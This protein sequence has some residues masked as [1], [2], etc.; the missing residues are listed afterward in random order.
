MGGP[1]IESTHPCPCGCGRGVSHGRLSCPTS[2]A[3]L[4]R[5]APD[6]AERVTQTYTESRRR[7]LSPEARQ[8]ARRNHLAAVGAASRWFRAQ[9]Q[10]AL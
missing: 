7:T 1:T 4:R 6:I 2:W 3:W 9:R 5:A 10:A 8:V